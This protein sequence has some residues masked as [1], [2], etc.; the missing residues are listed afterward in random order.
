MELVISTLTGLREDNKYIFTRYPI[1][2]LE[3]K[4]TVSTGRLLGVILQCFI[5][6]GSGRGVP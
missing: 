4:F 2:E 1:S 3:A 5:L 6:A